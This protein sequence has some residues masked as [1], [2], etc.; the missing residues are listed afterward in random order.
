M[1][2]FIYRTGIRLKELGERKNWLWAYRLGMKIK[3][4][5]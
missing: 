1:K 4:A 2:G 3:D 5:V